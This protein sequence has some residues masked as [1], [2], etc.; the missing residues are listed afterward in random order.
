MAAYRNRCMRDRGVLLG[1][2]PGRRNRPVKRAGGVR[3]LIQAIDRMEESPLAGVIIGTLTLVAIPF[4]L[5]LLASWLEVDDGLDL[6][7][8]PTP[9]AVPVAAAMDGR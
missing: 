1:A 2:Q 7:G 9:C 4:F 3:A 6:P 5:V 8:A